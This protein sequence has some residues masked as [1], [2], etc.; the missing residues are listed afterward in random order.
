MH[1]PGSVDDQEV[2]ERA[3]SNVELTFSRS[4]KG[5][6][7]K[8]GVAP[9][10]PLIRFIAVLKGVFVLCLHTSSLPSRPDTAARFFWAM[11]SG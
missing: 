1:T 9:E 4:S 10:R 11:V 7:N 5:S 8:V 6:P 3:M 2:V